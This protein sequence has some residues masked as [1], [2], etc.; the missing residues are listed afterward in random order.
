METILLRPIAD[1]NRTGQL[2]DWDQPMCK[3]L[4]LNN[5]FPTTVDE[6]K[7]IFGLCVLVALIHESRCSGIPPVYGLVVL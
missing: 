1:A 3:W 7:H 5:L 6:D 4:H 2:R